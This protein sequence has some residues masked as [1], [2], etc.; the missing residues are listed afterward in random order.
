MANK[1]YEG[2]LT[3]L[4]DG[5]S[6]SSGPKCL[7]NCSRCQAHTESKPNKIAQS[8]GGKMMGLHLYYSY[9]PL[10]SGCHFLSLNERLLMNVCICLCQVIVSCSR[11]LNYNVYLQLL[12]SR[13]LLCLHITLLT[14]LLALGV[15]V[16]HK[17][18]VHFVY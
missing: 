3:L 11:I 6:P 12:F 14:L 1:G 2:E 9:A 16:T 18:N 4:V 13:G 5:C 10:I 15:D 17:R 8:Q 7:E